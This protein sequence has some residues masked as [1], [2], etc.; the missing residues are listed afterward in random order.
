MPGGHASITGRSR[1][2]GCKIPACL[3]RGFAHPLAQ[4][5]ISVVEIL[6]K[7]REKCVAVRG[8]GL[9]NA[10]KYAAVHALRVVRRLQEERW[11]GRDEHRIADA[12]RTVLPDVARHLA[13]THREAHQGEVPQ[14]ELRHQLV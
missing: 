10:L 2:A 6:K 4:Q 8:D 7:L 1:S 14:F 3:D 12:I 11:Y 13:A 9:L 5:H